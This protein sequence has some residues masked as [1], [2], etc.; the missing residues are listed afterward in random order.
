MFARVWLPM[1]TKY[2]M[3]AKVGRVTGD[4]RSMSSETRILIEKEVKNLLDRLSNA[5][6]R[7]SS[8]LMPQVRGTMGQA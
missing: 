6:V 3:N 7:Q 4:E 2:G 8:F 5:K 1:V